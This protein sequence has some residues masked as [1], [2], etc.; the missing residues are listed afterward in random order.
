[1][2]AAANKPPQP[3]F[4]DS[5]VPGI[6]GDG[7]VTAMERGASPGQYKGKKCL[8]RLCKNYK[9]PKKGHSHNKDENLTLTDDWDHVNPHLNRPPKGA[10]K[11][12]SQIMRKGDRVNRVAISDFGVVLAT[13]GIARRSI[14]GR[15]LAN[16]ASL[17]QSCPVL[18]HIDP[19]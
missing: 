8:T 15:V 4:L 11:A 7:R 10:A 13:S 18:P 6:L 5:W 16:W 12:W 17:V 9:A 3:G 14:F 1:M 19:G 2:S